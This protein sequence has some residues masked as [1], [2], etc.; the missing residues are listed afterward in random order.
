[1]CS[2]GFRIKQVIVL[3]SDIKMSPGKAAAQAS[4]AAV[5]SAEEA[6]RNYPSWWRE[7]IEGGQCK[8]ILKANS[9]TE[10]LEMER[11]ARDMKLPTAL[12][13]DMGLTEL[14]PG[15]ITALGIGPAPSNLIDKITGS[16]PLY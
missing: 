12:I 16:L 3:R 15:T 2:S 13:T 1:M 14:E 9:E 8:I 11:K 5:S 4:H 7:W 10:L 6:R